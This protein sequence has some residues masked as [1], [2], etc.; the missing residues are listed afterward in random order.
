M[1]S[2]ENIGDEVAQIVNEKWKQPRK[3]YLCKEDDIP[4]LNGNG[5]LKLELDE[6]HRFEPSFNKANERMIWFIAGMSGSGKSY[7]TGQLLKK[8]K[9]LYPKNDIYIFSSVDSD[10]SLDALKPKRI[11]LDELLTEDLQSTDFANSICIF[12]DV[13]CLTNKAIKN[14]VLSIQNQILQKGRHDNVSCI[15]TSH[16]YNDGATTKMILNESV[17]IMI[18]PSNANGRNLKYLLEN[19][20]GF[21]R[22]QVKYIKS[23]KTRPLTI[24]K[25]YPQLIISDGLICFTKHLL[26]PTNTTK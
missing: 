11:K 20:L 6:D 22:H 4:M 2:F 23:L 12:D 26:D 17:R 1:L 24:C 25:T 19:Y 21:D 14:K 10:K 15:V 3:I 8:Y 16:V 5:F 9:K 18:F 13:D 7:A